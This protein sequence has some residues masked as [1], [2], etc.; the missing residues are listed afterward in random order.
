MVDN[1]NTIP[2]CCIPTVCPLSSLQKWL[3]QHH[4]QYRF[5]HIGFISLPDNVCRRN[6]VYSYSATVSD[7]FDSI[8]VFYIIHLVQN[9]L[10]SGTILLLLQKDWRKVQSKKRKPLHTQRGENND[11]DLPD[12]IEN[13]DMYQ[14]LLPPTG[15]GEENSQSDCGPQTG[16]NSLVA[17]G[18]M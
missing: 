8:L 7:R 18:S 11:E 14:P 17:Y 9:L 13:P 1:T 2:C 4:R 16:V 5:C 12:R 3:F 6:K 10:S 15:G